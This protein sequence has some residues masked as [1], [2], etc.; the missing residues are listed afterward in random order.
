[1]TISDMVEK[2]T[3][4]ENWIAELYSMYDEGIISNDEL[5]RELEEVENE[6]YETN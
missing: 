5:Q 6:L 3:R 4:I 1:M 2:S